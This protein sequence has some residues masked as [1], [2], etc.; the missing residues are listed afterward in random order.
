MCAGCSVCRPVSFMRAELMSH[1]W[2]FWSQP[3]VGHPK[4]CLK[5]GHILR[6]SQESAFSSYSR[7]DESIKRMSEASEGAARAGLGSA[8]T[9]SLCSLLEATVAAS[10]ASHRSAPAVSPL[11]GAGC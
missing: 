11:T 3:V 4:E 6:G 1:L 10:M 9:A 7:A 8:L 5:I 2:N